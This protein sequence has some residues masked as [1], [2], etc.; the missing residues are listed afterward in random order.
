MY[1]IHIGYVRVIYYSSIF[2]VYTSV[3]LAKGRPESGTT[4]LDSGAEKRLRRSRIEGY[5][6]RP[7][8][9]G[10]LVRAAVVPPASA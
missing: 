8:A 9:R 1:R 5:G 6:P 7:Q 4:K 2:L 10:R 3:Y